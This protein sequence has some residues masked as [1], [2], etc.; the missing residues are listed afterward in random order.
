M[1]YCLRSFNFFFWNSLSEKFFRLKQS[2]LDYTERSKREKQSKLDLRVPVLSNYLF[3]FDFRGRTEITSK[4][5]SLFPVSNC[6]NWIY[7]FIYF[8][9]SSFINWMS[10]IV[11][12]FADW[13]FC[14][15][16]CPPFTKGK[17]NKQK[18]LLLKAISYAVF[19]V[20]CFYFDYVYP[21]IE[22]CNL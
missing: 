5:F 2:H 19:L 1:C 9:I 21:R 20:S 15:F 17:S 12:N 6:A 14:I 7:F 3:I 11:D 13:K 16:F 4:M 18:V 22:K 8:N 10:H